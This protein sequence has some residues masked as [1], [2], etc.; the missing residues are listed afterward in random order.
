MPLPLDGILCL[1]FEASALARGS[2]PIEVAVADCT[3]GATRSWLIRPLDVWLAADVWDPAAQAVHGIA[4]EELLASGLP[5]EQVAQELADACR[6]G[7]VLA[8]GGVHDR[9][10]LAVLYDAIGREPP[11]ALGDFHD[12]A[13][14]LALRAARD[15]QRAIASSELEAQIRFPRTHRAAADAR[16]LAES[17][18]LV[19]GWP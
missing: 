17:L 2:W 13:V 5:V 1:D 7:L 11:F 18:R 16:S 4:R 8:D 15:P 19:A 6:D 10:W 9:Y 3:S 14:A 12:H